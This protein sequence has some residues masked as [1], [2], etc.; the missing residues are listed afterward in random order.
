MKISF[1]HAA[2]LPTP[3]LLTIMG[4]GKNDIVQIMM[5]KK[6]EGE[7]GKIDRAIKL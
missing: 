4:R 6:Q 1:S 7:N 2:N 3:K 5:Q